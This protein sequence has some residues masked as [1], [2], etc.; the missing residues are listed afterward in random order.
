MFNY[1]NKNNPLHLYKIHYVDDIT[2]L[3][4]DDMQEI[5]IPKEIFE[6]KFHKCELKYND[7]KNIIIWGLKY[8]VSTNDIRVLNVVRNACIKVNTRGYTELKHVIERKEYW[9]LKQANSLNLDHEET[10]FTKQLFIYLQN[11][12]D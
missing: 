7:W 4:R 10:E 12:K 11:E 1:Q 6:T 8:Y 3:I 5:H 2:K 9:K